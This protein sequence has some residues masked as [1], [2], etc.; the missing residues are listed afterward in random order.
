[1]IEIQFSITEK[2]HDGYCSGIEDEEDLVTETH[3][4]YKIEISDDKIIYIDQENIE[5]YMNDYEVIE[6]FRKFD[7]DR[8]FIHHKN[9]SRYCQ[10]GFVWEEA[11]AINV[12]FKVFKN[13]NVK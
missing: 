2:S 13:K 11:E 10:F 4:P 1:M 6:K 9:G 7:K 3:G 8:R 5:H 12:K